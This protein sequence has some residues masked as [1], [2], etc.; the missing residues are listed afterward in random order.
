MLANA[1]RIQ[2]HGYVVTETPNIRRARKQ[3]KL[4]AQEA[5]ISDRIACK[6]KV[7][8]RNHFQILKIMLF[9]AGYISAPSGKDCLMVPDCK[10]TVVARATKALATVTQMP[11]VEHNSARSSYGFRI[12]LDT[13]GT[14]VE[15]GDDVSLFNTIVIQ[16]D[17]LVQEVWDTARRISCSWRN[18]YSK[19]VNFKPLS[20]AMLDVVRSDFKG[21]P[22]KCWMDIRRGIY[23]NTR[24]LEGVLPIGEDVS[25]MVFLEDKE[26]RMDVGVR[27]CWALPSDDFDDRNLPRVQLTSFDGCPLLEIYIVNKHRNS[28]R[29]RKEKLMGNWQ[30]RY[31]ESGAGST[32]VTYS[33]L[34]AFKFPD[35][36]QIYLTCNV[37]VGHCK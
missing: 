19:Q 15:E 20:I 24:P 18:N 34:S 13:C 22:L 14:A 4:T 36:P 32:L 10:F 30:S 3:R 21:E 25:V 1:S 9:T 27:D 23:P 5:M 12:S 35:Y 33:K 17:P 6:L 29:L 16:F 8:L 2:D 31:E 11:Y 28:S 37:E 7:I 26:K